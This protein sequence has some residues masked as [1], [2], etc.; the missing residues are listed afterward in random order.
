MNDTTKISEVEE[1]VGLRRSGEQVLHST[2]IHSCGCR[3]NRIP[4][5]CHLGIEALAEVPVDDLAED[6][7]HGVVVE[8]VDGD[9]VEVAKEAWGDWVTPATRRAHGCNEQGVH[10]IDLHNKRGLITTLVC[11]GFTVYT[12]C[13]I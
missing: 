12:T 7:G 4:D 2:L 1:V 13:T 11:D 10:Q 5:S 3:D 6:E 8:L 9:G